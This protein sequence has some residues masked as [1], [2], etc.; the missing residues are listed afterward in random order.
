MKIILL[1]CLLPLVAFANDSESTF[2]FG[3]NKGTSQKCDPNYNSCPDV[4]ELINEHLT[5][6][7]SFETEGLVNAHR[8]YRP[9]PPHYRPRPPYYNPRPPYYRNRPYY[10]PVGHICRNGYY[11]CGMNYPAQQGA[12]C[13]CNLITWGFWGIVTNY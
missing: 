9:R 11:Y 10:P 4:Q 1:I 8:H 12:S 5:D 13:Y 3:D 7:Q 6:T 2:Y